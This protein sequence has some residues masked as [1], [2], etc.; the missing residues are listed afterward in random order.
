MGYDRVEQIRE[1]VLEDG[2]QGNFREEGLPWCVQSKPECLHGCSD[3][4]LLF[5]FVPVRDYSNAE[6]ML[7]ATG[8]TPLLVSLEIITSKPNADGGSKGCVTWKV[9]EDP[10]TKKIM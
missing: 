10:C 6:R 7:A 9:E 5:Q 1:G 3:H 2:L 8:R 4:N